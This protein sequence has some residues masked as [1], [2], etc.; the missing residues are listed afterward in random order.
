[1][2]NTHGKYT[3]NRLSAAQCSVLSA[4]ARQGHFQAASDRCAVGCSCMRAFGSQLQPCPVVRTPKLS[5]HAGHRQNNGSH[6]TKV[7]LWPPASST[8]RLSLD[9]RH[10]H[11]LAVSLPRATLRRPLQWPGV[12]AEKRGLQSTCHSLTTV[13]R[14]KP[15]L[16]QAAHTGAPAAERPA[17]PR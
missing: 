17:Q 1:M 15:P 3:V 8:V 12:H 4:K 7:R 6:P 11:G 10:R 2:V 9:M 16:P 13:R 14:A 5:S